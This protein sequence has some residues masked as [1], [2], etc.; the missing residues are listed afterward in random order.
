M[1]STGCRSTPLAR[2][3]GSTPSLLAEACRAPQ[4]F[5]NFSIFHEKTQN[6]INCRCLVN[7]RKNQRVP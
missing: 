5:V 7:T 3:F 1:V 2:D 6:A 4:F